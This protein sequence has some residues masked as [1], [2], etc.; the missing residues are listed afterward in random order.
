MLEN[1]KGPIVMNM[2]K[3]EMD[4]IMLSP[5]IFGVC[6]ILWMDDYISK[7]MLIGDEIDVGFVV[8]VTIISFFILWVGWMGYTDY[9][10]YFD[11]SEKV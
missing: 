5:L 9:K 4:I 2:F 6:M 11:Y 10:A 8:L 3:T 7:Q 1:K